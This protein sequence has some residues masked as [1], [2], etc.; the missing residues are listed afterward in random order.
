[1]ATDRTSTA[2]GAGPRVRRRADAERSI[3]AIVEAALA[4]FGRDADA[5]M[6]DIA[7]AAGVGR[8]TLY[9][10]FPS[11]EDL[12][13]EVMGRAIGEA[14][15]VLDAVPVQDL[16]AGQALAEVVRSCWQVLDR[17]RSLQ[18]A[19]VRVL[20]PERMRAHHDE[21]MAVVGDLLARGRGDGT[22]RA[23]LPHDWLLATVYGLLHTAAA[24]VEAGRLPAA[25]APG[26]LEAT[27]VSV[28]VPPEQAS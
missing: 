19:A 18:A 28:L 12:L 16:P 15:T 7:R 17:Y 27:L 1:M 3:A 8:V 24:E 21:P 26:V 9:S 6:A 2:A 23:D 13:E 22:V 20:G 4:V 5:T 11:R 25:D 14:R 10:H